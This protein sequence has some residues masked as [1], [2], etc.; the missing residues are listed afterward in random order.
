MRITH[1]SNKHRHQARTGTALL[2]TWLVW[3]SSYLAIK[4]G[5]TGFPP[6][7][8][9]AIETGLAAIFL[10]GLCAIKKHPVPEP[11]QWLRMAAVALFLVLG[12]TGLTNIGTDKV[13]SWIAAGILEARH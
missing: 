3:G 7:L 10:C 4:I 9:G 11:R 13:D 5:L 8:L 12:C 6:L 2:V 1:P